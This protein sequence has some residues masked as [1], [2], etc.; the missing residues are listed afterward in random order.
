MLLGRSGRTP[1]KASARL[2]A[3]RQA[4]STSRTWPKQC[5]SRRKG[6]PRGPL[7]SIALNATPVIETPRGSRKLGPYPANRCLRA[8]LL[9]AWDGNEVATGDRPAVPPR[10]LL[11]VERGQ[12]DKA[13]DAVKLHQVHGRRMRDRRV[14]LAL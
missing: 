4:P 12:I 10:R 13:R 1:F 6:R 7:A 3:R 9:A 11:R 2:R 8:A 5:E 14:R